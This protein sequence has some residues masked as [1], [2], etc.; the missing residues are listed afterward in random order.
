MII[1]VDGASR[2]NPG[3]AGI[4][5]F[6]YQTVPSEPL[7]QDA[8]YLGKTTNNVAE[9]AALA[10]AVHHASKL[11]PQRKPH[12]YADSELLVK[13]I[14]G[15][16]RVRNPHL[17]QWY[18]LV[19]HL[20]LEQPFTLSHV[21]REKNKDADRLANDGIDQRMP[22]PADFYRLVNHYITHQKILIT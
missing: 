7:F 19:K 4:G 10:L 9:Y 18:Q 12:I 22:L 13:Q 8:Y 6:A 11:K 15:I 16:Y 14:N 20:C 2:G 3:H 1:F 5:A 21:R 17:Q